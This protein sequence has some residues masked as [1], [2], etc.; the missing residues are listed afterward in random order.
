AAAVVV[1]LLLGLRWRRI[2][3]LMLAT[4][5]AG[6]AAGGL[7]GREAVYRWIVQADYVG[8]AT[9][10]LANRQEIWGRALYMI[11]DYPFT[12]VGLNSFAKVLD[13]LYPS[14]F[15]G[16]V[17]DIPHAHNIYLQT[18]VDLGLAGLMAL[19]GIC[20]TTLWI[21][22]TAYRR[23]EGATRG[24]IAGLGAGLLAYMLFGMTDAIAL[25]AKPLPMLWGIIGLIA[26]A[27][28]LNACGKPATGEH[29][30]RTMGGAAVPTPG[31][32]SR[33]VA[34]GAARIGLAIYWATAILF[35]VL[36]YLVVAM[37]IVGVVA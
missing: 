20:L 7:V 12:G 22:Y 10:K 35:A 37:S 32:R 27:D 17:A 26:A 16:S 8:D 33:F 19:L 30:V 13:G 25:G 14:P 24:A 36:A 21:G 3:Y 1:V 34:A 9:A 11:Q 5:V 18:A 29:G 31:G 28:R 4:A 15:I 2:G 23:T 6:I